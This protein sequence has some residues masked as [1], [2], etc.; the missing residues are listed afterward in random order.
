MNWITKIAIKEAFGTNPDEAISVKVS[1]VLCVH[2]P[3]EG[4]YIPKGEIPKPTEINDK[5]IHLKQYRY[6]DSVA[7][8]GY[9]YGC[10]KTY[11]M[12]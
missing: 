4:Y 6:G 2:Y 7:V 12:D 11:Y 8:I 5:V 10:E 3:S 9:C 1:P